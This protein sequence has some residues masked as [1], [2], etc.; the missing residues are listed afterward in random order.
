[1]D[2]TDRLDGSKDQRGGGPFPGGRVTHQST[3]GLMMGLDLGDLP[4]WWGGHP[5][6]QELPAQTG[7]FE[8]QLLLSRAGQDRQAGEEVGD[9]ARLPRI[10][11]APMLCEQAVIQAS[12]PRVSSPLLRNKCPQTWQP[13]TAHGYQLTDPEGQES[14]CSLPGPL[15]G[16]SNRL[17]S[18]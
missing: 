3:W 7:P 16:V 11:E 12:P 17:Q 9:Q 2:G 6:R 4:V 15:L 10:T 1:M 5:R 13:G 8:D 14:G 18:G